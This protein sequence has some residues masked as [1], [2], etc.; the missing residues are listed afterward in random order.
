MTPRVFSSYSKSLAKLTLAA[1]ALAAV[2][3]LAAAPA[4]LADGTDGWYFTAGAGVNYVPDLK[5]HNSQPAVGPTKTES[6]LGMTILAGGGYAFGP[7][8]AEAEVGWRENGNDKVT[9]PG[10]GQGSGGGDI[11]PWSLMINGYYDI[12]TGT[13]FTPYL[14]LGVGMVDL[15]GK[16]AEGGTTITDMGRTGFGYQGIA[17]VAYKVNDQLSIKG[18][19]RYLATLET[20]L[21]DDSSSVGAGTAKMT[22]QSHALLVGFVYRFGAPA[23]PMAQA[24]A[25]TAAPPPPAPPPPAPAPAPAAAV[26]SF[27]VFFEFDKSTISDDARQTIQQAVAAAKSQGSTRIDLTGHTDTVGTVPYNMALSIRRAEAVKKVLVELGVPADEI[28]VVGKGKADL[29]VKTPDGVREPKNRRVE[30]VLP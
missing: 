10:F 22:Y 5:I 20:D 30:I 3:T 12:D 7:W 1:T 9:T 25:A 19:Y 16:I 18:E 17:G 26:H 21:P 27:Q 2:A 23:Q 8:R 29:L 28:G 24:A 11:E 4:A 13:K 15:T 6:D 14:G